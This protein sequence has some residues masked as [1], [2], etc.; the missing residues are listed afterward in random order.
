[1]R[2]LSDPVLTW[3]SFVFVLL[4]VCP[5]GGSFLNLLGGA[6]VAL[7]LCLNKLVSLY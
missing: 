3:S 6:V 2:R 1:M 5:G 4:V 7:P